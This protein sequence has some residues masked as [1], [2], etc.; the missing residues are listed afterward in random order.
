[1]R[2]TFPKDE[3]D[4]LRQERLTSVL[5]ARDDPGTIAALAFA[6]TL[7]GTTHRYGTATI[8]TAEALRSF[9]IEDLRT[10]YAS[11]FR[12]GNA[13][14]VVVGDVTPDTVQSL[15]ETHFGSWKAVSDRGSVHTA[16]P[17]VPERARREVYLVDKPGA[18]QSEIRIG[19]V[20]V[21]RSTPDYFSIQVM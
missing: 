13:A 7:Y 10:Y 1:L 12:P 18:P 8:G 11:A 15:L 17:P 5:Q 16:M 2:P 6:R 21:A 3:V 4:R 20:G 14:L 9:T 19:S